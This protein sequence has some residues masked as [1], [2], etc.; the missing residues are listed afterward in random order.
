MDWNSMFDSNYS[1]YSR[2]NMYPAELK[3]IAEK[4][5]SGK[6]AITKEEIYDFLIDLYLYEKSI[7]KS[8]SK[9]KAR[10]CLIRDC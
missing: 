8:K 9:K 2:R 7:K 6:K 1:E 10:R 5:L 4:K 3:E